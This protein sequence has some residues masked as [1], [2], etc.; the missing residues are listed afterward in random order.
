[1]AR[2]PEHMARVM[3]YTLSEGRESGLALS[4]CGL[5]FEHFKKL[6]ILGALFIT[7]VSSSISRVRRVVEH[8]SPRAIL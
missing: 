4:R 6:A 1:M 2:V 8:F 3:F 7:S 5:L